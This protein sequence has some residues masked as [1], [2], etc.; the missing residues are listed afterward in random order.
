MTALRSSLSPSSFPSS[1]LMFSH[2]PLLSSFAILEQVASNFASIFARPGLLSGHVADDG[3]GQPSVFC[4]RP[5]KACHGVVRC[6]EPFT[7]SS[8]ARALGMCFAAFILS[9][10]M[11]HSVTTKILDMFL[12]CDTCV[13][14]SSRHS[15]NPLQRQRRSAKRTW[16]CS[17]CSFDKFSCRPVC[18]QCQGVAACGLLRE[19]CWCERTQ[20]TKNGWQVLSARSAAETH[21][22]PLC[23]SGDNQTAAPPAPVSPETLGRGSLAVSLA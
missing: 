4:G 21:R 17:S 16:M 19:G 2:T 5:R 23:S 10:K 22:F 15:V 8:G 9:Q 12:R 3:C 11:H 7:L 18:H 1:P 6:A 20:I 13:G 14:G